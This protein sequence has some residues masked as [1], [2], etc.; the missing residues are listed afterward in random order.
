MEL[1]AGVM[2]LPSMLFWGSGLLK[3]GLLLFALGFAVAAALHSPLPR[4]TQAGGDEGCF[5]PASYVPTYNPF[6]DTQLAAVI[7]QFDRDVL[8]GCVGME[9]GLSLGLVY[10]QELVW[11]KG[12]GLID[13]ANPARGAP[14]KGQW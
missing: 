13:M 6:A 4:K 8:D 14:T 7:E 2:L 12:Y 5:S 1:F 10:G 11:S 3:D 9:G